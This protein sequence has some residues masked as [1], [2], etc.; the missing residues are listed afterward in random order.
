MKKMRKLSA[1]ALRRETNDAKQFVIKTLDDVPH[2]AV[3]SI[4]DDR[5]DL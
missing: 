1:I 4:E 3:W 5:L 2:R